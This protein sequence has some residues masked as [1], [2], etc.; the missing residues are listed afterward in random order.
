MASSSPSLMDSLFQRSLDD[1]IKGLRHQQTGDSLFISKVL[2][3]IRR[4]IK[5]TDLHTKSTALHK[6]T[7]LH[8]IHFLDMSW[9]AFHAIECISS[10]NFSHKKIGYLAIS[11]SFH[12]STPVI[13]LITN[14]LRKDLKSN[15]EAEVSLALE[16]LSRIGNL[17]L[18]RDLTPEVFTLMATSK[19]LVKKKAIGLLLMLF[20]KYPDSVRVCFK[21]LV[22]SLESGDSPP[23]VSAVIG[24]FCELASRDPRAYLPLAPEFYKILVDSRNNWVLIKVLK[25]FTKLAPLEPRLAK[26]IVEPICELM[27]KTGAKSLMFECIRTILTSLTDYESAVR[28]SAGRINELLVD[29]DPNLR[30]L[31]LHALA[32]IAPKH[33]WAVLEN[34]EV[35]IKSLSDADPNIKLESLRLVMAMMSDSNVVEICRVLMNYANKSEPEFCNQILGSILSTCSHNVYEIVVDFD[36]YVS[37][38]GEMSRV[39]HCQKG[40]EIEDQLIDIA[41]RVE[42]ARPELVRVARDLVIDPALLGNSYLHRILSAAAWVCGEYVEFTRRP[43][44]LVEALLQPRTSL[45]PTHVRAVYMESAFKVLIFLLHSYIQNESS[46]DG[47]KSQESRCNIVEEKYSTSDPIL[48]LFNLIDLAVSPLS[49]SYD[50]EIQERTRNILGFLELIRPDISDSSS[51]EDAELKEGRASTVV[52]LLHDSFLNEL[53][54]ISTSAQGRVAIPDGLVLHDNLADL[55]AVCGSSEVPASWPISFES[56]YNEEGGSD[57]I[58]DYKE[59][60]ELSTE[61]TSLLVEHR[62]RHG[63]YYLSSEKNEHVGN[64]YPPANELKSG[65]RKQSFMPK[66]KSKQVKARPVVVKLDEGDKQITSEKPETKVD[67]ISDAVREVLLGNEGEAGSSREKSTAT[68][69]IDKKKGKV[70]MNV[71]GE[72]EDSEKMGSESQQQIPAKERSKRSSGKKKGGDMEKHR[73]KHRHGRHNKTDQVHNSVIAQTPVVTDLLL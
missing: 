55:E 10:S 31:G 17:D 51:P 70:K 57:F 48:Y 56:Y 30:Y 32:L 37:L 67:S 73:R 26:K 34:K 15:A 61:S 3:E 18:C 45:L 58:A 20:G 14:Q 8:S 19:L 49:G 64:D 27:R 38:L 29:E 5:S 16:C 35:V 63:L 40:E 11:Q 7:Y 41:M 21:R 52:R 59:K 6:L 43:V 39:Q 25:I 4:E 46:T 44:E 47:D 65:I 33:I 69:I 13:L 54:P 72:K 23:I 28:L 60:S 36:W 42:D 12:E 53:G 62:K 24:V 2:E 68:G 9:A 22:E 50:V 71:E 1:I 66:R